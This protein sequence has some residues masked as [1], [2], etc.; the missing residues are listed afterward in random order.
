MYR[1]HLLLDNLVPPMLAPLQVGL[2][3][4]TG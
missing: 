3:L 1:M 2:V 4:A